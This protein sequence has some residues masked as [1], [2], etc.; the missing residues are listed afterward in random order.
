M[1][2]YVQLKAKGTEEIFYMTG[3][4]IVILNIAGDNICALFACICTRNTE[5]FRNTMQIGNVNE[6]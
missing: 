4:T 6:K 5:G 1:L 3:D 2:E